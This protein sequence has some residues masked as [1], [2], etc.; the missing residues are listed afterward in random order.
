MIGC[1]PLGEQSSFI[2]IG[3]DDVTPRFKSTDNRANADRPDE[4]LDGEKNPE[5]SEMT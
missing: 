1:F 2:I 3:I 5:N 4:Q